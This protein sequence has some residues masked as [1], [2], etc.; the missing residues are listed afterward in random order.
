MKRT[1]RWVPALPLPAQPYVPGVSPNRPEM[2]VPEAIDHP[3]DAWLFDEAYLYGVDLYEAHFAWEAHEAW[4]SAWKRASD[5]AR[6]ELL[7]GL[8]QC[9]AAVVKARA[10]AVGGVRSLTER[11]TRRVER[12]A[13]L[14]GSP[15]VMGLD[16]VRFTRAMRRWAATREPRPETR[17]PLALKARSRDPR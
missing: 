16:A 1:S 9:T 7:Q 3:C 13:D 14:V 2:V 8:I 11:G 6:R 10:K 17:P 12:A 5:P 4:E 15:Y